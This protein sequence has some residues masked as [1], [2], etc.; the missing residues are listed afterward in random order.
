M[1][2]AVQVIFRVGSEPWFRTSD[3]RFRTLDLTLNLGSEPR[4]S[5]S[6]PESAKKPR[7]PMAVAVQVI[8]TGRQTMFNKIRQLL[9]FVYLCQ[10]IRVGSTDLWDFIG[11]ML[12]G[13]FALAIV[14]PF[15]IALFF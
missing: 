9:E 6:E 13:A 2:I 4:I 12:M 15:A 3:L 5:G 8:F 1:A 14:I 10:S 7:I 11:K